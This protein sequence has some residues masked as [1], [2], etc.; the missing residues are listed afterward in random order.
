MQNN[1]EINL[2]SSVIDLSQV[3]TIH[4]LTIYNERP[5]NMDFE[6]YKKFR[7]ESTLAIRQYL[8][9][10]VFHV[11]KDKR[12][13]QTFVGKTDLEKEYKRLIRNN[14]RAAKLENK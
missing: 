13:G 5:E 11:S 6:T 14:K 2:E 1:E 8:K 3:E 10:N 9:G 4:D 12:Q 7:K